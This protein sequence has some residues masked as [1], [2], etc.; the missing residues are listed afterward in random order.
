MILYD[1]TKENDDIP[2][3]L[4]RNF[5]LI[6]EVLEVSQEQCQS[7][8]QSSISAPKKQVIQASVTVMQPLKVTFYCEVLGFDSV[9]VSFNLSCLDSSPLSISLE[10]IV[11]NIIEV[12]SNRVNLSNELFKISCKMKIPNVLKLA[13]GEEFSIIYNIKLFSDSA[14]SDLF[15]PANDF[16]FCLNVE[17]L[18]DDSISYKSSFE[19]V[20]DIRKLFQ[21]R[22]MDEISISFFLNQQK[23][24]KYQ[25][26]NLIAFVVNKSHETVDLSLKLNIPE[27]VRVVDRRNSEIMDDQSKH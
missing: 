18:L 3:S 19:Q 5:Q 22:N 2:D 4:L 15:N 25:S 16:R 12:L 13:P 8:L 23:V 17:G 14:H 27:T 1:K 20:L 6:R 26:F 9:D 10:K 7:I 21:H 24:I 11:L